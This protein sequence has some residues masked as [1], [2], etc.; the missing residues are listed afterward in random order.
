[1]PDAS[2]D[3]LAICDK[4]VRPIFFMKGNNRTYLE[5]DASP[6]MHL[7]KFSTTNEGHEETQGLPRIVYLK[8][9]LV[10]VSECDAKIR[11]SEVTLSPHVEPTSIISRKERSKK[12]VAK[13]ETRKLECELEKK[14]KHASF[15]AQFYPGFECVE[16]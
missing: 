8:D 4:H 6:T 14:L 3:K 16:C 11:V 5:C 15:H 7:T 1:M 13:I 9:D 10:I 2:V 12:R